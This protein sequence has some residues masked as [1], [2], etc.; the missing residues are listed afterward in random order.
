[1]TGITGKILWL[2]S[3]FIIIVSTL[4]ICISSEK[5]LHGKQPGYALV[6]HGGSFGPKGQPGFK[7]S[8]ELKLALSRTLKIGEAILKD[9]GSS[10][11]EHASLYVQQG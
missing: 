2:T 3:L 10:L 5:A 4:L 11:D 8:K 1:M 9:G 7:E 6:V